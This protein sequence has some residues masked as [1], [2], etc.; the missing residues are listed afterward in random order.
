M[1]DNMDDPIAYDECPV[2]LDPMDY[3]QGQGEIGD[4]EGFIFL[5]EAQDREV[6]ALWQ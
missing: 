4:Y 6:L 3:C 5:E 2:C 1:N